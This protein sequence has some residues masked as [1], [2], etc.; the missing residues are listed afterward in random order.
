MRKIKIDNPVLDSYVTDISSDYSSGTSVTVRNNVS[1]AADDLGVFGNPT[2][3][4]TELKKISS[5]SGSTTL[6]LASALNFAH[7]KGTPVYKSIWD[8]VSIEGRSSSAG[9]FAELTQSAIQWDNPKGKTV[10]FHSSGDDNWQYRF[11]F[12]NTVTTTYSEYSPTL[13]GTGFTQTQMGY[14]I[15]EARR[16][17]GDKEGKIMRVDELLRA[18]TRAKNIIRA[19]NGRYWFWK[20]NGRN[21]SKSI[22]GIAG[23]AVYSLSSISDFGTMDTIECRYNSG[24]TDQ[25]WMLSRKGDAEFQEYARDLNRPNTDYPHYY[26]LLPPDSASTLGYFEVENKIKSDGVVTFYINYYKIESNYDSVDDTTAIIMPEILE[27]YLIAEIF[28]TK[29]NDT[30]AKEYRKKFYGPDGR[31]KTLALEE[32]DGIALLDELDKQ[33]KTSQGQPKQLWRFRG[34][35]AISRLYGSRQVVAPDYIRENYFD[36]PEY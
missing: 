11:R 18:A 6:T 3:E 24:G 1:F 5:V 14:I 2:E 35:R 20:V 32:L 4:L 17:A 23:T 8:Q 9:T 13:A 19:H 16:I 21:S 28:A 26:R 7:N 36:G 15:K 33:Y 34:Q 27:D 30:K 22:S 12:Y 31:D 29:G 25:L 10:Y